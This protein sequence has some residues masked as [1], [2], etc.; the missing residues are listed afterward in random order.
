MTAPHKLNWIAHVRWLAMAVT[1]LIATGC[2]EMKVEGDAKIFQSSA[3]GTIIATLLGLGLLTLG[4]LSVVAS[5]WPDRKPRNEYEARSGGTPTSQRV[6]LA[7]FGASMGFMG[8]FLTIIS[9]IF[10]NSLHVTVY[11]DRVEMAST[12]NQA[13]GKG[14]VVPFSNVKSVEIKDE[15]GIGRKRRRYLIIALKDGGTIR[16]EAG[17]NELHALATIQQSLAEYQKNAPANKVAPVAAAPQGVGRAARNEIADAPGAAAQ[18]KFGVNTRLDAPSAQP[19]ERAVADMV[20]GTLY[21]DPSIGAPSSSSSSKPSAKS[22]LSSLP[23][24]APKPMATPSASTLASPQPGAAATAGAAGRYTLKRYPIT[25]AVPAEYEIVAE[26]TIVDVGMKLRACYARSWSSVT[27]VAVN[28]DGT[29]TCNWDDW[30]SFTY[31]MLRDDLIIPKGGATSTTTA[32][33]RTAA[34]ATRLPTTPSSDNSQHKLKRYVITIPIAQ[35]YAL[36]RPDTEVKVDMKLAACFA[37]HWEPVTVVAIN[38]DGTITC[39][40]DKWPGFTYKM[41]REDLTIAKR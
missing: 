18:P 37:G 40:W 13:R 8:F 15:L 2:T 34:P 11:P 32:A 4:G 36:V 5:F 7:I 6:G 26:N 10:P 25:I 23:P 33:P 17:N 3:I 16:Q 41:V 28:D 35:G 30:Q 1:I 24:V 39:A 12:F 20:V 27:V 14:V 38:S 19:S 9:L 29:I 22:P 21:S 31:I